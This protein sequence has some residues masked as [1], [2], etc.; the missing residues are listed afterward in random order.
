VQV[1][2]G[3]VRPN[4]PDCKQN[5]IRGRESGHISISIVA[6]ATGHSGRATMTKNCEDSGEHQRPRRSKRDAA[7]NVS[8]VMN[9]KVHA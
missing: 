7:H 8:R 5:E 2:F 6:A 1:R 3:I 4:R 9:A